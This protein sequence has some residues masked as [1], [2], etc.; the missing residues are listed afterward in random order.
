MREDYLLTVPSIKKEYD[1]G[2]ASEKFKFKLS[3]KPNKVYLSMR[4]WLNPIKY[5]II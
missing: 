3:N 4:P 5:S 2:S 1:K